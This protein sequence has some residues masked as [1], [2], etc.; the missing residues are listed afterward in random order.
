MATSNRKTNGKRSAAQTKWGEYLR[1]IKALPFVDTGKRVSW[2]A[3]PKHDG[4]P[5]PRMPH[6]QDDHNL[7]D[8]SIV[9]EA[10][11]GMLCA[12]LPLL[13]AGLAELRELVDA[14]RLESWLLQHCR[15]KKTHVVKLKYALGHG[16]LRD[17][18]ELN[19]AVIS[20]ARLNRARWIKIEKRQTGSGPNYIQVNSMLLVAGAS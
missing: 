11:I 5:P 20:L 4:Y 10:A 15:R 2:W 3:I 14:A 19:K 7:D 1:H 6:V 9:Q 17:E 18:D 8:A 12:P 16:P 13:S